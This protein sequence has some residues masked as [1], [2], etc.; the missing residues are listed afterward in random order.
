MPDGHNIDCDRHKNVWRSQG[1]GWVMAL[2]RQSVA[3][4]QGQ[5]PQTALLSYRSVEAV[6][7]LL[8]GT[9]ARN[10]NKYFPPF[11]GPQRYRLDLYV[12][13]R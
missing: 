11:S 8:G 13:R 7:V 12:G 4:S 3:C 10:F 9:W 2:Y 5:A 6:A 1:L